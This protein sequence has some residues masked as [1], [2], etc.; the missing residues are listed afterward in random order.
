MVVPQHHRGLVRAL[1][2]KRIHVRLSA[3]PRLHNLLRRNL[4]RAGR[5]HAIAGEHPSHAK[6][7]QHRL[8]H[9]IRRQRA[10]P[11]EVPLV[12]ELERPRHHPHQIHL[13]LRRK[14]GQRLH[15][16]RRVGG[17]HR[18]I[19]I[20]IGRV[21][22]GRAGRAALRIGLRQNNRQIAVLRR[23]AH[24]AESIG[25]CVQL[26][27]DPHPHMSRFPRPR[28]N[29]SWAALGMEAHEVQRNRLA[30]LSVLVVRAVIEKFLQKAARPRRSRPGNRRPANNRPRQRLPH[31]CHRIVVQL[32]VLLRR[33]LPVAD[34][35]LV[36]HLEI[37]R[38]NLSPAV[39][40]HHVLCE[41]P[42]QLAPHRVV[43]RWA[44][45]RPIQRLG[46]R[47]IVRPRTR[48]QRLRHEPQLHHRPHT[49]RVVGVEYLVQNR[50][51]V[52]RLPIGVQRK[53][54]ARR[55]LQPRHPIA[56][57]KQ[58]VRANG[59]RHRREVM[60]L[61]QQLPPVLHRRVVGFVVSEPVPNG[62]VSPQ[63]LRQINLDRNP[64]GC[65]VLRLRGCIRNRC[66][67]SCLSLT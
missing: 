16:H 63:R 47:H 34:V 46:I 45:H 4:R 26:V 24:N 22:L 25:R 14:I 15:R 56:R 40:L 52:H 38:R 65:A 27:A 50:E 13:R 67:S 7:I 41:S 10:E 17:I 28:R 53:H 32:E 43:L 54:V 48:R 44:L 42:H 62:P 31:P 57:R 60:Q 20:R 55:P 39:S 29:P 1:G 66:G 2:R 11:L 12:L 35:R 36:P 5:R 9:A 51:V 23:R 19:A 33:A 6:D 59:H 21:L 49:G 64:R 18:P 37:P 30:R 8:V 61:A 58:V 3:H